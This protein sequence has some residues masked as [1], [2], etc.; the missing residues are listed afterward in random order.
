MLVAHF[1][2]FCA[3]VVL[4]FSPDSY[5]VAES[6]GAVNI[7]VAFLVGSFGTALISVQLSLSTVDGTANG[8]TDE[9]MVDT[10]LG[11]KGTSLLGMGTSD[12]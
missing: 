10:W 8:N 9:A 4:G 11:V 2:L 7:G 12:S 3:V 6:A 1:P 5:T